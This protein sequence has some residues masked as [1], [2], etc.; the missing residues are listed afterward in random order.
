M[1]RRKFTSKLHK[2]EYLNYIYHCPDSTEKLPLVI[3][4][5]GAGSRGDDISLIETSL[6]VNEA[7]KHVGDKAVIVAPQC[8]KKYWFDLFEVL[9]EFIDTWRQAENVD[10]DRVYITGGSMGG[11]TTWQMCLSHPDW[12]AAAV[13]VCGGG[14]YWAGA[15]LKNLPIWATHGALD[16]VVLPEESI[17]MVKAINSN[18]GN[19]KITIFPNA[20]HDAWTP[21]YTDPEIWN[22]MFRQRR[23]N[24]EA[25]SDTTEALKKVI[26]EGK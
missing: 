6:S 24:N 15:G 5:H 19:A 18:G 26:K 17:H 10:T 8:H 13:P 22:W 16:P 25:T 11:Y 20:A 21:T 9:T 2:G 7:V 14:M 3:C 1:E 4:I 12:F 23:N